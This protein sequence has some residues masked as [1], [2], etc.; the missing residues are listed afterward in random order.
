MGQEAA[1]PPLAIISEEPTILERRRRYGEW[2]DH[3]DFMREVILIRVI[4]ELV[5]VVQAFMMP[6]V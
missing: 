1:M 2:H 6:F 5:E 3:Q 4:E